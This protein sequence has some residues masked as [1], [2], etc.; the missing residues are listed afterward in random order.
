MYILFNLS[1]HALSKRL[2]QNYDQIY[3]WGCNDTLESFFKTEGRSSTSSLYK[4]KFQKGKKKILSEW[5][6]SLKVLS[7]NIWSLLEYK[8]VQF[9]EIWEFL[10][11][12]LSVSQNIRKA[13][14][15]K[16]QEYC[17]FSRQTN[18]FGVF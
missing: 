11:G 2:N 10:G 15:K 8:K 3:Y 1:T 17:R 5:Y 18:N 13:S 6:L 9:Y 4:I 16:I 7:R 14:F 12:G